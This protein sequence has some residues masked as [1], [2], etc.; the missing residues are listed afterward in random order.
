MQSMWYLGEHITILTSRLKT[1]PIPIFPCHSWVY[2]P[3]YFS[4][5]KLCPFFLNLKIS[6]PFSI[7]FKKQ[8][9]RVVSKYK[10]DI[11][12]I[13]VQTI[14]S[15]PDSPPPNTTAFLKSIFSYLYLYYI[16][17]TWNLKSLVELLLPTLKLPLL[18][19]ILCIWFL[20]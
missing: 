1:Y 3:W 14:F 7:L 11:L 10:T 4:I 20:N 17:V 2:L 12:K 13:S 19:I 15:P 5:F 6:H 8:P 16:L 9:P 18:S